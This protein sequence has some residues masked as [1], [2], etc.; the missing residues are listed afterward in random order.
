[1]KIL[2]KRPKVLNEIPRFRDEFFD[3]VL[4]IDLQTSNMT[5]GQ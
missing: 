2:P 1:M 3:L 5:M 4:N